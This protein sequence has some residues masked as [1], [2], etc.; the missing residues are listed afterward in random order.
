[1]NIYLDIHGVLIDYAGNPASHTDE[2]VEYLVRSH[3]VYWLTSYFR[4]NRDN[5]L[6]Y[7]KKYHFTQKTL[8]NFEKIKITEWRTQKIEGIDLRK[9]FLWFDD[10]PST[11]DLA[12]LKSHGLTDSL[13][14]IDLDKNPNQLASLLKSE[15]LNPSSPA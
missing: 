1:M 12:V 13:I 10:N 4:S 3:S 14:L 9:P 7:L 2:F 5:P 15:I 6:P 11:G 8:A